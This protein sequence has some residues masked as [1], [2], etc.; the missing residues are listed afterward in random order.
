MK[1][2]L[3]WAGIILLV[4]PLLV[5][6]L[7]G[8]LYLPPVQNWAVDKAA[9]IASRE[10]G[11]QISVGR[12]ELDFPL[13][14]GLDR[15]MVIRQ[16]DT[17]ANIG[18]VAVDVKLL[19]LLRSKMVVN[20][21]EI[22][23]AEI[24]T[25][26]YIS[27]LQLKG[28]IGQF[29][30][31]SRCIDLKQGTV[32]LNGAH[33]TDA[34]ITVVLSDTAATDTTT[35]QTA[36][37]VGLDSILIDRSRVEVHTPGDSMQVAAWLG[38]LRATDGK[39][40]LLAGRYSVGSVDWRDG[41]LNV[42][43][44][45]AQ[46]IALPTDT[47]GVSGTIDFNH[48]HFTD[49]GIGID[50]IN[51]A[52]SDLSLVIRDAALRERSGLELTQLQGT[53]RMD[54][55]TIYLP[56]MTASTPYSYIHARG[57]VDLNVAD[58]VAP[59]YMDIDLNASLGKHDLLLFV[60]DHNQKLKRNWPNWP[61]SVKAQ[62]K[63][64]LEKADIGSLD[65]TLPTVMHLE[66]SG[67]AGLR[68]TTMAQLNVSAETYDL[69]LLS[70][71]V[72]DFG[73]DY[74]LPCGMTLRGKVETKGHVYGADLTLTDGESTVV[75][76]GHLNDR[77][78]SYDANVTANALDLRR[79]LPRQKLG[80]L[81]ATLTAKGRGTDL[82]NSKSRLE[83]DAFVRQLQYDGL[84]IDSTHVKAT[85]GNGHAV[86]TVEGHN[87]LFDGALS[88]DALLGTRKLQGKVSASLQRADLFALK[89]TDS[90]LT[91]GVDGDI[92]VESNLKETHRLSGFLKGL[93]IKDSVT[94]YHPENIGVLL[95]TN[96][97]TTLAR[98]Q[99]GSFIAKLDAQGGYEQLLKQLD[100]LST[101]MHQQ[102]DNRTI[103]HDALKALLPTMRLYVTS[104]TNNPVADILKAS[105]GIAFKELS[106]NLH[107]SPLSGINGTSHL[108]HVNIDST[109]IDTMRIDL[110]EKKGVLTFNG[111]VTN[112]KKNPQFVFNTLFDGRLQEHG[113]SLG[114][115]YFD[116]DGKLG[117]RL[118]TQATMVSDGINF[119]LI[120]QEPTIGYKKFKLNDDNFLLLRRDKRVLAKVDMVS[121][122]GTGLKIYSPEEQDS[123][124]LQD[125]TIS[126]NQLDL[127]QLTDVMPYL[128][129]ITGLLDGDFHLTMNHDSQVSVASDMQV[130]RLTYEGSPIGNLSTE[131]VYLQ[132]ENDTHAVEAVLMLE[133]NEVGSLRGEYQDKNQGQLNATMQ[134]TRFPL[135]VANGFI[136][137]QIIG[138]EGFAEGELSVQG[139]LSKLDVDGVLNL[140]SAALVSQP[141]GVRL[142]FD[143]TPV[144][145][146]DARLLLEDFKMYAYNNEP[147]SITGNLD[148]HDISRMTMDM[149]MRAR[150][151]Q[152]I[153]SK[154]TSHSVA[155]GKA[156]VN[157]MARL[158]GPVDQL[159]M[160]GRLDVL[161]TTDLNYILLDSPLSADNQMD[162]LVKFTSFTDS[163]PQTVERPQPG[164]INADLSINIDEGT[165]VRCALNAD[166]TNYV[167]LYGGGDLRMKYQP[168]GLS[169]TG[170]YTIG[171]GEM[172][173]S[174]P[175]IPLKTFVIQDGSY[176]EFNGDPTNPKLNLTATERVKASVGQDG[177]QSRSVNFDCGVVIT[178]TLNDMGLQFIISAPEDNN[179]NSELQAMS[180]EERG[181]LAVTM[182]T[183]GMYLADGNTSGF[184][185]NSA[186]SS[187]LQS[188][189]NNITGNALKTLDLSVGV[190][191]STDA[192]GA[193]HTDYSFK[194]AKRFWNNRLR[195]Q[196]GGTVSS[197]QDATATGQQKS[198]FDNVVMEYRLSPTSNQYV[199]LFYNQNVYD[200]L[201]GYTSEYGGGFIWR[202]RLDSFWDI[203]RSSSSLDQRTRMLAPRPQPND[204]IKVRTN[205]K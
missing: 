29:S 186:L 200:W 96:P 152:I 80:K 181:K 171:D 133:G 166:Q 1:K 45:S 97:D 148:F 191:N 53:V 149:R 22:S 2:V 127:G 75:A 153:N 76:R 205:E 102:Y 19:P 159:S 66:A 192:S 168:D 194:F 177:G 125:L 204:S 201:E 115:R 30:A 16:N 54:S 157:V 87:A 27:D 119:H 114:V 42:D 164:G 142:R 195:V 50:S 41:R 25:L 144:H 69:G 78:M 57:Q 163:I 172:K 106:A 110:V 34:D 32:D 120:P 147:L 82:L 91:I 107:L 140:D 197:D 3:K 24:N 143:N 48:L 7:V 105:A 46:P 141:Y 100:L 169:M 165:H 40:D 71:F 180:V 167:D 18:H 203:F 190:D 150:N 126:L 39:L 17:I 95:R 196:I 174:L 178:K 55:T 58:S 101:E 137:D 124:L 145:I 131:L 59:G 108:Y 84:N 193:L 112:N 199:S 202:R 47:T 13:D 156:F 98:L 109:L 188:E 60:D 139:T 11:M 89:L 198:F 33:L 121:D 154:Q 170:R 176:V 43:Q 20:G 15:V 103:D 14:L 185:M 187:F 99:S 21:L 31:K 35:S 70:T 86:A 81:S 5:L 49:I 132:R 92:D 90:P 28:K 63:G 79:F 160:R 52:S 38:S 85:L 151:F 135:E 173:Y 77:D 130:G 129:R 88:T 83:A 56:L 68:G 189:I 184:S 128:P 72:P 183:T 93:Y 182:L 155:W 37:Y 146:S 36:W 44:A 104:A 136:T 73:K 123:T 8:L 9:S 138:F 12:V 6:L 122:D 4:P 111:Q 179:V 64:N 116:S 134:L 10:T 51:Y 74:T 65:V 67:T 117:V 94:T 26:D 23:Q 161:G 61:L 118:G 158:N 162:E 113:A 62:L 175:V